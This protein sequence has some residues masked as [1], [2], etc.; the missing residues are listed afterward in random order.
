M[1]CNCDDE[2]N[3]DVNQS[4]TCRAISVG[5]LPVFEETWSTFPIRLEAYFEAQGIANTTRRRAVLVASLLDSANRVIQG[6]C[7]SRQMNVLNN[8][9]VINY[10]EEYYAPEVNEIAA[11]Y[12]FFH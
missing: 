5:W 9:D 11:R 12:V 6:S 3:E 4:C 1:R 2:D 7:H 10:F 8:D